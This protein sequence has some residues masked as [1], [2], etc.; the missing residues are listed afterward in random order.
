VLAG[1]SFAPISL[2]RYRVLLS[3]AAES[4]PTASVT[5]PPI[6]ASAAPRAPWVPASESVIA[7]LTS[8][9]AALASSGHP[10]L[11][12]PL[13]VLPKVAL[14]AAPGVALALAGGL[15]SFVQTLLA[16]GAY[17]LLIM[18]TR[19]A[20]KEITQIV[21]WPWRVPGG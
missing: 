19:A 7:M 15:S 6:V 3:S 4:E 16:L 11:R 1:W 10:E 20:P 8:S 5:S 13:A 14:A 12:P 18:A 9:A 2:Q 21:P 17:A